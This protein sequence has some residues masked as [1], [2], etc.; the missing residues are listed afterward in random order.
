MN[1]SR[2]RRDPGVL[3]KG[4]LGRP[5]RAPP[6]AHHV[7][8]AEAFRSLDVSAL[9]ARLR[10]GPEG[11]ADVEAE[12]RLR[13]HGPNELERDLPPSAARLLVRALANP[14]VVLLAILSTISF[15]TGDA[16][17]G[18]LML[19][20]IALGV[21]LRLV[22]ERRAGEASARLR[23]LIAVCAT[24]VRSGRTQEIK[25][26]RLVPG[27]L[28]VLA[29]GDM[30][31]ADV[32]IVQAK[33]LYV[34]QSA[35]TGESLPVEKHDVTPLEGE[36][37]LLACAH[38][39]FLGTS[40]QSG[41]ALA[42]VVATGSSTYLGGM[43]KSLEDVSEITAFDRGIAR[44]TWLLVA[45]TA[46]MVPLVFLV[47]GL[48]KGRW[49][50]AFFFALAV[51]VGLTPEM[52]P[53]IVT[54]CLGAGSVALARKKVVVKRLSAIQN[55]GAMDVLCADK[56]GTLTMD[57]VLLERH[58]DVRLRES[59]DVLAHAYAN[60]RYQTGLRSVL[61]RAI[62]AHEEAESHPLILELRK[63]DEIP[64]DFVRRIVS[65]VVR[66]AE[67]HDRLIAK[68]APESIFARCEDVVLDGARLP[69]DHAHVDAVRKEHERLASDG[70]RVLAVAFRDMAPREVQGPSAAPYGTAD[71]ARLSLLGFV[72]FLDPPRETAGPALAALAA[73]GVEVKV[74][75]GDHDRVAAK[76]CRDV[77]LTVGRVV[78]GSEIEGLSDR[79]LEPMAE[80]ATVFARLEPAHKERIVRA[81]QR[82]GHTVGFMGDG[83]NDAPALHAADV[84][85]SVAGATD[86]AKES[87]DVVLLEKSLLVVDDGVLEGRRVFANILKYVRMGTSSNFGNVLSVLVASVFVPFMPMRPIQILANNLLYDVGQTV[88]PTDEVDLEDVRRPTPWDLG[89]L[90]R[91]ILLVGPCS[92]LFDCTTFFVLLRVFGCDDLSTPARASASASLFQTGWFVESLLT[93]TL[94]IHVIRTRRV[95]FLESRA[96]WPLTLVGALVVAVGLAL[97]YSPLASA[98]GFVPLPRGYGAFLAVTVVAYVALTQA[99]KKLLL[100]LRWIR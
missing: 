39:A 74:L 66:T 29:A 28:V 18:L 47:N 54:V 79:D 25:V 58:C 67:G 64:F 37:P 19:L 22:Q 70:F 9:Y 35:L 75:T 92:S 89:Q 94:V 65:V 15:A 91:F 68:G 50:D 8:G 1:R 76:V 6:R 41:T 57:R 12:R 48:T 78:L 82:R 40:V 83:I 72:A 69:M 17:A 44:L 2:S 93:Q 56:T 62:L 20:M 10:T 85:I 87:A 33:D 55:L 63:V 96:S 30:I 59:A 73:H 24:A 99:L 80:R 31:P 23:A 61:D 97:P 38:L 90:V 45:I 16:R 53:M 11:L 7:P 86:I 34:A 32:R 52:L 98:L 21:G 46:T 71:E 5:E 77:G 60:S 88:I 81:L 95:P 4:A 26:S 42:V 51:G 3:P 84:G 14:L 27:D 100:R 13:T 36:A 49:G 43:A